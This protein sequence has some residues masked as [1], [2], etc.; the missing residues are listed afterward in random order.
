MSVVSHIEF[1]AIQFDYEKCK[2]KKIMKFEVIF[3]AFS[4]VNK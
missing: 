3:D 1:V 2:C 4:G